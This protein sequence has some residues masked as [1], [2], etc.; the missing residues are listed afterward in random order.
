MITSVVAA[1]PVILV[2]MIW[3]DR[4]QCAP[5]PTLDRQRCENLVCTFTP[6]PQIIIVVRGCCFVFPSVAWPK[7]QVAS[8][9]FPM[10]RQLHSARKPSARL[11]TKG[12]S[13]PLFSGPRP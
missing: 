13:P 6:S 7:G 8:C 4:F 10:Q 9:A 3:L 5:K 2:L 11:P 12:R 1:C